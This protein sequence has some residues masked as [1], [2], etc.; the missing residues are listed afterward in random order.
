MGWIKDAKAEAIAK[1]AARA[2]EEGRQVFV[3][4]VNVGMTHHL[5]SGSVPGFAEQ[6]EAVEDAGWRLD[7]MSF[8]QDAKDKP[9]G[10]FLFR[11][12]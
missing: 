7:Q 6:I 10:Y 8:C 3:A 11:R 4:R 5:M 9:E 12:A 2:I 1:E